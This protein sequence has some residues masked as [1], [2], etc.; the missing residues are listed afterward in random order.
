MVVV[1]IMAGLGNQ[2]LQYA[3]GK[4]L[5]IKADSPLY[6]DLTWFANYNDQEHP[7][8][9]KLDKLN[10]QYNSIE[11]AN[12]LWKLRYTDNFK[13]INPFKLR[14]IKEQDYTA[15]DPDILLA[16]DDILL[17][18]FFFS[19]KYF[20]GIHDLLATEFR[21]IEKMEGANLACLQKMKAF[22]SVSIHIRRGDYANTDFHGMLEIDYYYKAIEHIATA[23]GDLHLFV[24]SDEP[25]WVRDNMQFE[26]PYEIMDFN[27]DERNYLDLELMKHCKHNV[28]A[29]STFSW[30]AA[31]LNPNPVKMVVAPK[32]WY[33]LGKNAGENLPSTWILI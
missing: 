13:K 29:N 5:S 6:L 21:P 23:S 27:K 30:W 32:K 10:T 28:I 33:N 3:V 14:N 31:W 16:G 2:M 1:K 24:F 19:Y 15:F 7:R 25:Q 17:E 4:H 11:H 8:E 12:I 9:F 20:E 26:H 18:G 22:N